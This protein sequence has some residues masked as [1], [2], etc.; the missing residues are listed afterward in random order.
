MIDIQHYPDGCVLPQM[1]APHWEWPHHAPDEAYVLTVDGVP[2]SIARLFHRRLIGTA[3][4]GNVI[5]IGGVWT[6]PPFRGRRY[7]SK[8]IGHVCATVDRR[9]ALAAVLFATPANG[10]LYERQGFVRVQPYLYV[11]SLVPGLVFDAETPQVPVSRW[12]LEPDERF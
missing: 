2:A 9:A 5:G 1:R 10:R 12:T 3:L 11:R 4:S 8:L 7:A 6:E